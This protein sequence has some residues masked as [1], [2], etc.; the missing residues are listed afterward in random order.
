L[1]DGHAKGH[2]TGLHP[3][4]N[5]LCKQVRFRF[6]IQGVETVTHHFKITTQTRSPLWHIRACQ[7]SRESSLSFIWR[8]SFINR[9]SVT[10]KTFSQCYLSVIRHQHRPSYH[11]NS[12][13]NHLRY[14]S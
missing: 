6:S 4:Q 12:I 10:E 2:L 1:W 7:M 11:G 13:C 3:E 8:G 9:S 5:G 14:C